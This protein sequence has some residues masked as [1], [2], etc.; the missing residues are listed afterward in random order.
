[1]RSSDAASKSMAHLGKRL[2]AL[3]AESRLT[4]GQL[5]QMAGVSKAMLSQIE[6]HKV[7]PTI[8]VMLK[9]ASALQ[10]NIGELLNM[11]AEKNIIRVIP[12]TDANYSLQAGPGC[13]IRTLS[14][15][16]LEKNIEFYKIKL[17]AG[18]EQRSEGHF[19]GTQEFLHVSKGKIRV[20][21]GDQ[22]VDLAAGDSVQ[23]RCDITHMLK[24]IGRRA[25]E[26]Y[27]V[28]RFSQS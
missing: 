11:P 24:N 23:Y 19:P 22:Q 15:L 27:M 6:Q 5:S 2:K 25:A 18:A 4:L 13:F 16:S 3:R 17:D 26:A 1:M 7:N 14:P 9:V 21:S 12:H 10:L 28:V 8:A 20:V